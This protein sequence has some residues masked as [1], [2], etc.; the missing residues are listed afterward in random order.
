MVLLIAPVLQLQGDIFAPWEHE[1]LGG[2]GDAIKNL[3]SSVFRV[4]HK[5]SE[6]VFDHSAQVLDF[7][8]RKTTDAAVLF[9][10]DQGKFVTGSDAGFFPYI[11]WEYH[12]SAIINAQYCFHLA[13]G[14]R[15]APAWTSI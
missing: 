8:K 12:L 13:P 3:H 15:V 6:H 1:Q 10:A 2:W 9:P 7:H 14:D 5:Q 11:F 4:V